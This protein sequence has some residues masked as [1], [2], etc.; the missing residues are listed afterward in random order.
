MHSY[1]VVIGKSEKYLLLGVIAQIS[2]AMGLFDFSD[3]TRSLGNRDF[4]ALT[5]IL[6]SHFESERA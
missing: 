6:V 3:E 1:L 5:R 4:S 2:I